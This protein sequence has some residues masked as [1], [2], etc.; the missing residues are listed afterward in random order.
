MQIVDLVIKALNDAQQR[1]RE[2][3]TRNRE[4][5]TRNREFETRNNA[6]SARDFAGRETAE[7][8]RM[9]ERERQ[10]T[11]LLDDCFALIEAGR[12]ELENRTDQYGIRSG[13]IDSV[14]E[15]IQRELGFGMQSALRPPQWTR[16]DV[17]LL[18]RRIQETEK[19]LNEVQEK[20][21]LLLQEMM[22]ME[23]E[24]DR[25]NEK[26]QKAET[27]LFQKEREIETLK[28]QRMEGGMV[29]QQTQP[30]S[31]SQP[32]LG[33]TRSPPMMYGSTTQYLCSSPILPLFL[34]LDFM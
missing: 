13:S 2:L 6:E 33:G 24:R 1:N 9:R 19:E 7:V 34:S 27:E 32:I 18:L 4:F 31:A 12:S 3:E 15:R 17:I 5:E 21:S 11:K 16:N 23:N 29:G 10:L 22:Q 20:K 28:V 8:L 26:L 30:F 25:V 14:L